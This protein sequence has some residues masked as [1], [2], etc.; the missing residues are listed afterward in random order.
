M[1]G[2]N[3]LE[4]AIKEAHDATAHGGVEKTSKWLTDKFICQ[5]FSMLVKEYVSSYNTCQRTKYSNK[6]PLGQVTMLHVPARVW[7]DISTD[8]LKMSPVFT[9][10][11]TLYPNITLE[12]DHMI[13]FSRLCTI[14]CRQSGFML[15][16]PVS[17]TVT[18]EKCTD[19]FDKHVASVIG[20][21][22]YIVFDR[23]TLFMS[24]HFMDWAARK[25]IKLEP[26]T[27]YHP[28]TDGQSEIANKAI[29][30]AARACKVEGNEWLHKLSQ[31]K[32]K[33]N[34]RGNTA[35]QHSPFFSL[36][37]FEA[38]PGHSSFTY[39]ITPYTPAEERHLH[40]SRNL[41]SSKVKQA[42]QANKKGTVPPL[43]SAGQKVLLSTENLN[44]WNTSN[45]WHPPL[46]IAS[47]KISASSTSSYGSDTLPCPTPDPTFPTHSI[48]MPYY[49][50]KGPFTVEGFLHLNSA[51][52]HN[53]TN[54]PE[55]IGLAANQD[56][57]H[58]QWVGKKSY[59]NLV[60]LAQ[61]QGL[62]SNEIH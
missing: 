52:K 22:Y 40:T 37:G 61:S 3:Y 14:V 50:W 12:E 9:Y 7:T 11:S 58:W 6:P 32:L 48:M 26:S 59:N 25:G 30:Q 49:W 18:V 44:L 16:I 4:D 56:N 5:A 24:D 19:T 55:A 33:L 8:F 23:D 10:C 13:C 27:A 46:H 34:S 47:R 45:Y 31:I 17:D 2:E 42:K 38:K 57:L 41:Y 60:E 53:T 20:Y 51:T 29:L 39:S 15:L 54:I 28:Q 21:P 35:R 62:P 1:N 43:L 36:L